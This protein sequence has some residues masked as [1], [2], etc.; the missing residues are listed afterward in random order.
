MLGLQ[1]RVGDRGGGGAAATV[2]GLGDRPGM[3]ASVRSTARKVEGQSRGSERKA[4][5]SLDDPDDD[6]GGAS[7]TAK[8]AQS[9]ASLLLPMLRRSRLRRGIAV[10]SSPYRWDNELQ[11]ADQRFGQRCPQL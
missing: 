10:R 9:G 7:P 8:P 4:R 11:G 5:G 6:F 3:A 1:G 2:G